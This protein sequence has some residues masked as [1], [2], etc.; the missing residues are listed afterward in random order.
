MCPL[1]GLSLV[2]RLVVGERYSSVLNGW[3]RIATWL[4]QSRN[5]CTWLFLQLTFE[6][7]EEGSEREAR[8]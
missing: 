8:R 3:K 5:N 2:Q 6:E 4:L 7:E 1:F